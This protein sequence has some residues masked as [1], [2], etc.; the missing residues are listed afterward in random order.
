MYCCIGLSLLHNVL[1]LYLSGCMNSP[2]GYPLVTL[3]GVSVPCRLPP[4]Q[5]RGV[6]VISLVCIRDVGRDSILQ[7]L[8]LQLSK[9]IFADRY[10]L[11][12]LLQFFNVYF[13]SSLSAY[14]LTGY[15]PK[16]ITRKF[17]R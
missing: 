3:R 11:F 10:F 4:S 13:C 14:S 6:S 8:L 2:V 12:F 15:E 9:C 16:D 5:L 17:P 1:I 7:R